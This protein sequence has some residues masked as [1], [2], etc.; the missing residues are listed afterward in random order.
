MSDLSFGPPLEK[1]QDLPANHFLVVGFSSPKIQFYFIC[2]LMFILTK[3]LRVRELY[4]AIHL[5]S[6]I[7]PLVT[8]ELK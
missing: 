1:N 7:H 4:S 2:L 3:L 8:I 5:Y 6:I